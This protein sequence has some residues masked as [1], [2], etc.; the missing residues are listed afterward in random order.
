MRC[1]SDRILPVLSAALI[2]LSGCGS[3]D[4][5]IPFPPGRG[6]A[7]PTA[8]APAPDT[9]F[10][11]GA[12]TNVPPGVTATAPASTTAELNDD[13]LLG[14]RHYR[15]GDYGLAE[16]YFRRT[17][18]EGSG[19]THRLAE[20]WLGLAASYDRLH[21]FELADRAYGEALK[22][23]G[24]TAELLNN[25]GYSYLLRGDFQRART[26][27]VA[28]L[29]LDPAN[30]FIRDNLDLLERNVHTKGMQ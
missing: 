28:A 21:R 30:P 12:E 25:Q 5:S 14:K 7:K 10:T 23:V 19:N 26:K 27:L 9:T 4:G 3:W 11:V 6:P 15:Q 17:V 16:K 18:E 8:V 29:D 20:A 13:L 1:W 2:L 22:I 24:P